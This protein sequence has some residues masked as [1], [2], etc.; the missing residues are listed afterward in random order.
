MSAAPTL[1]IDLGTSG[2]KALL[3]DGDKVVGAASAPLEVSH[4]HAGW[5]EHIEKKVTSV[6]QPDRMPVTG[7]RRTQFGHGLWCTA[8]RRYPVDGAVAAR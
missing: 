8:G 1:G 2:V 7:L 3:L 4:P 5:S 6:G